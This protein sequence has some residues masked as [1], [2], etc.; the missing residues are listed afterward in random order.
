MSLIFLLAGLALGGAYDGKI[1]TYFHIDLEELLP[2]GKKFKEGE[3]IE[4]GNPIGTVKD[5]PG[6][7]HLHF[8]CHNPKSGKWYHRY[9]ETSCDPLQ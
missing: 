1:Y 9:D 6:G 3:R 5:G 7:P 4:I 8:S 2:N